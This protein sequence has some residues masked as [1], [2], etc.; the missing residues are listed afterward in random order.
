LKFEMDGLLCQ[1][2]QIRAQ[3]K[4]CVTMSQSNVLEHV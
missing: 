2:G 1:I 4:F 3:G